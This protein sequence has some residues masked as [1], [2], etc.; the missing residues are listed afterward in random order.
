MTMSEPARRGWGYSQ[1]TVAA[2]ME[3]DPK[4]PGVALG[5]FCIK[6][7]IP[8]AEVAREVGVSRWTIYQW[9]QGNSWPS[10]EAQ[11]R[12]RALVSAHSA[13]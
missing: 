4:H 1:R 12:F 3:G 10:V 13:K 8:V 11:E 9:F 5:R 2:V 6:H 7:D